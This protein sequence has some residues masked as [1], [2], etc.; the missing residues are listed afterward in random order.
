MRARAVRAVVVAALL[1]PSGWSPSAELKLTLPAGLQEDAAQIPADNPIP[2][3]KVALGKK[4]FWDKRWSASG[5]VACV[6]CHRPDHGWSDSRRFSTDYAGRP[7][8]R[9]TPTHVHRLFHAPP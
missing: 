5:T 2:R 7:T 4:F 9:D 8:A 3:E 6:S 1:L